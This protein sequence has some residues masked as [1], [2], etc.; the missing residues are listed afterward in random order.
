MILNYI[1]TKSFQVRE[2]NFSLG[3]KYKQRQ[4]QK[5]RFDKIKFKRQYKYVSIFCIL[6]FRNLTLSPCHKFLKIKHLKIVNSSWFFTICIPS[7][8]SL[9]GPYKV[10]ELKSNNVVS[11]KFSYIKNMVQFVNWRI[12]IC[13]PFLSNIIITDQNFSK[14]AYLFELILFL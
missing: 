10:T 2:T 1:V 11:L 7:I 9:G 3:E 4:W 8:F 5:W 6:R 13:F 14:Q 12:H